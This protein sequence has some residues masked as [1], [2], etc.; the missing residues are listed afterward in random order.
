MKDLTDELP[1]DATPRQAA[2]R[3]VLRQIEHLKTYPIVRDKLAAGEVRLHGW[4]YEIE[5]SDV[6]AWDEASKRFH[7]LGMRTTKGT[8]ATLR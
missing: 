5:S 1:R 3:N 8:S 6:S 2:E 4:F 7:A